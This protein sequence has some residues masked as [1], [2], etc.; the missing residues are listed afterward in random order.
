M[1]RAKT[2]EPV[3]TY[4]DMGTAVTAFST[5]RHGGSSRGNYAQFNINEYCGDDPKCVAENKQ[6]LAKTLDVSTD[7]IV[8][9]HQTHGT[10]S[11][12]VGGDFFALRADVRKMVLEG[13]DAVMTDVS[14][15]CVGVS[16]ADC[17]PVL[18]FDPQHDAVCAIHA[19]WRGT[20]AGVVKK[21]VA[22]MTAAYHTNP[23]VV[24]AVIG[25]G[26]SLE[27]FEVGEEVYE[28]FAAAGYDMQA[29]SEL[30]GKW[31]I[32]L[33]ECNRRQLIDAGLMDVNITPSD[34]C[35]YRNADKYFSARRL[36]VDS[37]RIYTGILLKTDRSSQ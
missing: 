12:I 5:T 3:L 31:H 11:R 17:I 7:H 1:T 18:I 13:V 10:E 16:T 28:Q 36:G 2:D 37:G 8:V 29:I 19:G 23:T 34:I 15:V 30:R 32:D 21:T 4:Y 14:G 24:K 26:I 6:L 33:P 27:A 9:P 35:T 20:L 22:D 25:P